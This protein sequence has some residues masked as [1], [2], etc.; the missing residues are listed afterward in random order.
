[1]GIHRSHI[2]K[3]WGFF[4]FLF[5]FVDDITFEAQVDVNSRNYPYLLYVL[6]VSGIA[7]LLRIRNAS[8]YKSSILPAEEVM[9]AFDMHNYGPITSAAALPSG[10]LVVGRSDGSV[11]CF[12]LSILDPSAPG[13]ADFCCFI[14]L[15]WPVDLCPCL[16]LAQ[17]W[18][19]FGLD[20]I[21]FLS[22]VLFCSLATMHELRDD[23]G[24]SRLW[25]L[26]SRYHKLLDSLPAKNIQQEYL[27]RTLFIVIY[28]LTSHD[29]RQRKNFHH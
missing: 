6:T 25:G 13:T 26:M 12:Q 17:W 9:R 15:V 7:Y 5:S 10:C 2:Q 16:P 8:A 1:M 24:I 14:F 23:S 11:G 18:K 20:S 19:T 27:L 3:L 29:M 21:I 28:I 4:I 22:N